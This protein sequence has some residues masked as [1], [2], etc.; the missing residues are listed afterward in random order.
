MQDIL[1]LDHSRFLE[2]CWH[3]QSYRRSKAYLEHVSYPRTDKQGHLEDA[4]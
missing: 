2:T 3:P 1:S 4:F